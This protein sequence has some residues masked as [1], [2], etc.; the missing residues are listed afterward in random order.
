MLPGDNL[1]HIVVRMTEN[2][3]FDHMLGSLKAVNPATEGMS[4]IDSP[5]P[6][7]E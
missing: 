6:G 3:S 7:H 1:R 4:K 5:N 2:W